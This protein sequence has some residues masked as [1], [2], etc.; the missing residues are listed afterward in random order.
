MDHRTV[1]ISA[2]NHLHRDRVS[3]TR[4]VKVL[5]LVN[6]MECSPLSWVWTRNTEA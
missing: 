3:G 6:L 2:R 1:V 5:V 4:S